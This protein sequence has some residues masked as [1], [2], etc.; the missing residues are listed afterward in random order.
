MEDEFCSGCGVV[1]EEEGFECVT[2]NELNL[3]A[4]EDFFEIEDEEDDDDI[5]IDCNFCGSDM[6]IGDSACLGCGRLYSLDFWRDYTKWEPKVSSDDYNQ[7]PVMLDEDDNL[8]CD[9]R[10]YQCSC[11]R[12]ITWEEDKPK[13]PKGIWESAYDYYTPCSGCDHFYEASCPVL[14][15]WIVQYIKQGQSPGSIDSTCSM[16]EPFKASNLQRN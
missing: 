11:D 10:W 9:N 2:V 15:G 4:E 5:E 16:Y 3:F 1:F 14:R 13:I 6:C 12:P 8:C 7:Q